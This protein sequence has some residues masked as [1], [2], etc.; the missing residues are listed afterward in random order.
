MT[1]RVLLIDDQQTV[2]EAVIRY[3]APKFTAEDQM[4]ELLGTAPAAPVAPD[5]DIVEADSGEAGVEIL[6][7]TNLPEEAFAVAIVDMRMPGINGIETIRRIRQFNTR[8]PIIVYS[9]WVDFTMPELQQANGSGEVAVVAKP[10]LRELREAVKNV[11][12]DLTV[13]TQ[14][15]QEKGN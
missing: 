13:T 3:F 9:G 14:V 12:L 15:G 2:R 7:H 6:R 8:I 1:K 5:Y 11:T 10:N 4:A